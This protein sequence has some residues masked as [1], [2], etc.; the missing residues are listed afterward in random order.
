MVLGSIL[1]WIV[2][3]TLDTTLDTIW[4][5]IKKTGQTG[6][7][8]IVR[9]QQPETEMDLLREQNKI[10]KDILLNSNHNLTETEINEISHLYKVE[11]ISENVSEK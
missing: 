7:Y 10:L 8:L 11:K 9:R 6:Y 4:W 3:K 1:N 2:S 5:V